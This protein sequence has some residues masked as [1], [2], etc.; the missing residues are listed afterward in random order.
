M[1]HARA[2]CVQMRKE[3]S[4]GPSGQDRLLECM[5][6]YNLEEQVEFI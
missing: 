4:L 6:W 1:I 5:V 3:L 2:V